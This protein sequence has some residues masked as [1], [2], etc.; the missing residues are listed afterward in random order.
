[1]LYEV[2]TN[3]VP[4]RRYAQRTF[5]TIR[6]GYPYPAHSHRPVT[7]GLQALLDFIQQAFD[8]SGA[9]FN[10]IESHPVDSGRTFVGPSN[11]I[12]TAQH[13]SPIDSIIQHIKSKLRLQLRLSVK[14]L[15]QSREFGRQLDLLDMGALPHINRT[16]HCQLFR[17]GTLVRITS[18]NVCYTKL[19]RQEVAGFVEECRRFLQALPEAAIAAAD[20]WEP[21][22]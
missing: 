2:I 19:L 14:L 16:P 6:F 15:S 12:R 18:Y 7:L 21:D 10:L 5:A 17:R 9:A 20:R 3:P 13:I 4:Y 1:M 22:P 11:L 8:A